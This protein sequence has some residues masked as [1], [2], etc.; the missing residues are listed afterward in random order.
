M[1]FE[2]GSY[3][4]MLLIA[5]CCLGALAVL[6]AAALAATEPVTISTS[7]TTGGAFNGGTPDTFIPTAAG[8]NLYV[9]DLE[10]ALGTSAAV[11]IGTPATTSTVTVSA[12]ISSSSTAALTFDPATSISDGASA[13]TTEGSQSYDAPVTRTADSTLTSSAG[14]IDFT[15]SDDGTGFALTL[16]AG[17]TVTLGGSL[18]SAALSVGGSEI[19]L[20]GGSV[21]TAG[22]LF[23]DDPVTLGADTTLTNTGGA[24][25]L[26]SIDG[27]HA[28]SVQN[29]GGISFAGNIGS[30][31]PLTSLSVTDTGGGAVSDNGN[32]TTTGNQT[33]G[34]T[35]LAL[36]NDVTLSSSS[37]QITSSAAQPLAHDLT[38]AG[39]GTLSGVV[40]GAGALIKQGAGTLA[41]AG[42][43]TYQGGTTVDGGLVN[44]TVGSNL[45]TTTVTLD[46][47]GLQWG[48]GN[49]LDISPRLNAIGSDGATFDTNGNNVSLATALT[50]TGPITKSGAGTL[51]LPATNTDHAA[52]DVTAGTLDVTGT[53]PGAVT[54][55]NG[56][57]IDVSGTVGGSATVQPTG[58]LACSGGT[59]A[60]G[61]TNNGGTATSAPDAPTATTA[62]AGNGTAT[63]GFTPGAPNCLPVSYTVTALPGGAHASGAGSPI[64]VAG[65]TDNTSYTFSVTATNPIGSSSVTTS[66][67][68][69]EGA[70]PPVPLGIP[71]NQVPPVASGTA[72]VGRAL[73]CTTGTW[74]NTPSSYAYQWLRNGNAIAGATRPSYTL[75]SGDEGSRLA[76]DVI[77]TNATGSGAIALSNEIAVTIVPTSGCPAATGT[78][79]S[80]HLGPVTLGITRATAQRDF[81]KSSRRGKRY[82]QF[83]CLTP[84]GIRVVYGSPH[85][86]APLPGKTR[87]RYLNRVVLASTS[88]PTY[89]IDG[90]RPGS[91]LAAAK[92]ALHGGNTFVVGA[93]TWYVA[94]HGSVTDVLKTRHGVVEEI[95]I[96]AAGITRTRA[97]R[98]RLVKSIY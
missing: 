59:L 12:P 58:T 10:T 70:A 2:L 29:D 40:S 3:R 48:T 49:T 22:Q 51:T 61:V 52:T 15:S 80:S 55:E 81:P 67:V 8:A 75:T 97:Q 26:R 57:T 76:C 11:Q 43:N 90:I 23:L 6:P 56:A 17:T 98:L 21:T 78:I 9:G 1:N 7:A 31:T 95:G 4:R 20:N 35:A 27:A 62:V 5:M 42:L 16:S 85:L 38:I 82:E 74:S 36:Q 13:I 71:V 18:T 54:A 60:G 68:T 24:I 84:V 86:L 92:R 72:T 53:L 69:P 91:S 88:S 87:S 77:A 63:I 19:D 83:F 30:V 14:A 65:L 46:G 45:G 96:A 37:G 73:S 32:V 33:Y 66:A 89:V 79:H 44:F 39:A 41:L 93:N 50:G 94:A 47:G 64:T 28:L 25:F 34:A